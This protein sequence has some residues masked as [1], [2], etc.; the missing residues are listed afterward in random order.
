MLIVVPNLLQTHNI[1]VQNLNHTDVY[2]AQVDDGFQNKTALG[3]SLKHKSFPSSKAS[4]NRILNDEYFLS[5]KRR[6]SFE[7]SPIT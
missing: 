7:C 1:H 5:S 6:E 3:F 2:L 4:S